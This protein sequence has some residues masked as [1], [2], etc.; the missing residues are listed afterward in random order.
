[1]QKDNITQLEM[2][3]FNE[4]G[5]ACGKGASRRDSIGFDK[6]RGFQKLILSS[7]IVLLISVFSFSLGV[8]KG[9]KIGVSIIKSEVPARL[10]SP[11]GPVAIQTARREYTKS[12]LEQKAV[13]ALA[14]SSLA[15]TQAKANQ[16][17]RLASPGGPV[18]VSVKKQGQSLL[19]A[20][21]QAGKTGD[22]SSYTIQVASISSADNVKKEL[23]RLNNSGY[24]AFSLSKGKHIII[25]VGRFGVKEEA[26]YSAKKLKNKYPDCLIRRL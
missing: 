14:D 6:V 11:G 15:N 16:P 21:K 7:A 10:A 20:G 12:S 22:G 19:T 9:K 26:Q 17:A 8:E 13:A 2:F 4:Q 1:M 3:N 5:A 23:V 25:C 24:S 18:V